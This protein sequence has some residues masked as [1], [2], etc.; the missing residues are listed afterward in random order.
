MANAPVHEVE[1]A[2]HFGLP[3]ARVEALG[4]RAQGGERRLQAMGE[5]GDMQPRLTQMRGILR[6]Q[7]VQLVHQRLQFGRLRPLDPLAPPLA[8]GLQRAAQML[9][10]QKAE[11]HL[12]HD[13]PDQEE[14]ET[15]ERQRHGEDRVA[16]GALSAPRGAVTSMRMFSPSRSNRSERTRSAWPS[17]SWAG[18]GDGVGRLPRQGRPCRASGAERARRGHLAPV[19]ENAPVPARAGPVEGRGLGAEPVEAE[20]APRLGVA[21]RPAGPGGDRPRS[22][23]RAGSRVADRAASPPPPARCPPEHAR[24]P[25]R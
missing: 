1:E 15:C 12:K 6:D 13:R 10:R 23:P 19:H 17:S 21:T 2:Q 16:Q 11:A 14:A 24:A 4:R 7:R 18:A 9:Q 25:A 22:A 5:I 8:H 20:I 3:L